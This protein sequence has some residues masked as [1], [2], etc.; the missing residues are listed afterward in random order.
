MWVAEEECYKSISALSK[1]IVNAQ[2]Y[3]SIKNL[4]ELEV[5]DLEIGY[6]PNKYYY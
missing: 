1:E 6:L 2:D 3:S 5:T 4:F